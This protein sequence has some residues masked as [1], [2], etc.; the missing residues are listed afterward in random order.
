MAWKRQKTTYIDRKDAMK[1]K[2]VYDRSPN[3]K[4]R[5]VKVGNGKSR[6]KIGNKSY[7]GTRSKNGKFTLN[8]YA[9]E[10]DDIPM[11]TQRRSAAQKKGRTIEQISVKEFLNKGGSVSRRPSNKWQTTLSKNNAIKKA[12][13]RKVY[14][15]PNGVYAFRKPRKK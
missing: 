13:R 5:I 8:T 10:Y 12:G 9:I 14:Q 6:I 4:A 3:M 1:E 15:L 7:S 2:K 11:A